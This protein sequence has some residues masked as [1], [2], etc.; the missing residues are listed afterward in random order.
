MESGE[1]TYR[2][3][4]GRGGALERISEIQSRT[5]GVGAVRTPPSGAY[6]PNLSV[7]SLRTDAIDP[8][9]Q[10]MLVQTQAMSDVGDHVMPQAPPG[11]RSLVPNQPQGSA[12]TFDCDC[13]VAQAHAATG[14]PMDT[15]HQLCASSPE[16]FSATMEAQ[17]IPNECDTPWFLRRK[18]LLIGGGVVLAGVAAWLVLR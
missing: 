15:L 5:L 18:T 4:Y 17:G 10:R 7:P 11:G 1:L 2:R 8:T 13:M 9:R 12:T 3:L 14:A 6:V 16:S